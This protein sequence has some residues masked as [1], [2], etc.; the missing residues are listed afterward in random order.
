MNDSFTAI[1]ASDGAGLDRVVGTVVD[2][3]R[4]WVSLLVQHILVMSIE[5]T[6]FDESMMEDGRPERCHTL[7]C[8][9]YCC[10]GSLEVRTRSHD[11]SQNCSNVRAPLVSGI[12]SAG[13][14]QEVIERLLVWASYQ[15]MRVLPDCTYSRG[16][17]SFDFS[18]G[19]LQR[20]ARSMVLQNQVR[21]F[22]AR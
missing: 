10:H 16:F 11:E 8:C 1:S 17:P 5:F 19:C 7:S 6:L 21:A 2:S 18:T 20:R 3:W 4:R 15:V 22:G 13:W 12:V 9:G 14:R